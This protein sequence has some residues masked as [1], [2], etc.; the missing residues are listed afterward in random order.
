MLGFG[1]GF[2]RAAKDRERRLP[3]GLPPVGIDKLPSKM[4]ETGSK[5]MDDFAYD[6]GP[7]IRRERLIGRTRYPKDPISSL[8]LI[9]GND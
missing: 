4:I 7:P 9:I 6:D 3:A 5:I 8:R 1:F 2:I